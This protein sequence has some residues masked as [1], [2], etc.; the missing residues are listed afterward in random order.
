MTWKQKKRCLDRLAGEEG[1]TR[2]VW[3]E[4][5]KVCLAYPN[6]Y[7]TGMSNLGFQ[8]VY[9][10]INRHPAC[11]CERVFFPETCDEALS[12]SHAPLIS[13]ESQQPLADFDI[14]AFSLSFENDYPQILKMLEMAG[15]PLEAAA[16][17]ENNPLVIAG[18]IAATLNPEPLADFFDLFLLGEGEAVLPQFLDLA[19]PLLRDLRR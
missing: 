3:G 12:D 4:S 6:L 7:R 5:L 17:G 15:I 10:L 19:A 9:A 16:R 13:I 1:W 8:A 2:K 11:L 18:G 14:I